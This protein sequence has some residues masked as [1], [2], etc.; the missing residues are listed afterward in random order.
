MKSLRFF[1]TI[2]TLIFL[3]AICTFTQA[4]LPVENAFPNLSFN[5]PVDLQHAGDGSDRHLCRRA[6]RTHFRLSKMTPTCGFGQKIFLDIRNR[7]NDGGNEEG[8]LGL[9][10]PPLTSRTTAI[11]YVNYTAAE[12]ETH[13]RR[14]LFALR[15]RSERGGCGQRTGAA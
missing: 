2:A 1:I 12:S 11:F 8:L 9:A 10:F 6:G 14:A 4:Q 15:N 7:V 3:R 13:G 5:R